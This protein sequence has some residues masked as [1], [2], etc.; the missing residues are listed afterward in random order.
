MATIKTS[1][2]VIRKL[3]LGEADKILTVLTRDRG[4][5]RILAKG[6]RRPKA[7]L[8]GFA[9]LFQYND[10][11]LAEGR[12]WDIVTAATTVERFVGDDTTLSQV[13]LM[14]YIGELTDK[15]IEETQTV[16]GSF[17]LLRETLAYIKRHPQ[18][19][20]PRAYFEMKLLTVL[21]FAPELKQCVV[22]RHALNEDEPIYF[23]TRLGGLV[24]E[25]HRI[26]D[27]LAK[28]ISV[29][30]VKWL[31]LLQQYPLEAVDKITIE[32]TVAKET[33]QLLGDFVEYATEVKTKSLAVM[34]QLEE[35]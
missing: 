30:G 5:I 31:R 32:P 12:N 15:L 22:G 2:I 29:S 27:D 24:S 18:S 10:W 14:Y 13:G 9:D 6:V 19:G 21:G 25:N 26:A 20:S 16:P 1:G 7:K 17:E 8:T 33:N 23:S 28:P 34:S 4:K 3:N 11:I 35:S